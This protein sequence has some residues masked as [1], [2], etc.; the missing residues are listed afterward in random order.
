VTQSRAA[1]PPA[2]G[3]LVMRC[4]EKHAADR[5]QTAAEVLEA[6]EAMATPSG[7]AT[8]TAT[9]PVSSAPAKLVRRWLV[10][11][12]VVAVLLLAGIGAITWTRSRGTT[13][14]AGARRPHLL[15]VPVRNL[16]AAADPFFS[17]GLNEE[18][19]TRLGQSSW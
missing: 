19:A 14:G 4:L 1:V 8:P 15:V 17:A 6:L 11:G 2:L 13:A 12:T 3:A 16:G 18:V 5:P 7:G 10:F 9:V